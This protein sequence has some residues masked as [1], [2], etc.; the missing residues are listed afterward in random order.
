MQPG[1]QEPPGPSQNCRRSGLLGR[2][3]AWAW[4]SGNHRVRPAAQIT[5]WSSAFLLKGRERE[6][7]RM[8]RKHLQL[9]R[10]A[11]RSAGRS[12]DRRHPRGPLQDTGSSGA[13]SLP[14][15]DSQQED[16]GNQVPAELKPP[17]CGTAATL[18]SVLP[19]VAT[20]ASRQVPWAPME[21]SDAELDLQRSVQAVLRELSAQAPALQSDRGMWRWSL[22]KKVERDPGKSPALVRILLRELE[23]AES[24]DIR[25][26]I[27][28]LLHTLMYVVTKAT[29]ITEEL[30][31]RTYAFCTRLLTLPAPYCTVA[32]DCAI[33]LKTETVVPGTLY[34]RLVIAEQNLTNELY[35][36]QERAFLFVDP[37]LVSPSVCSALLLELEAAQVQQTPEACMRH[38]VS[39]ALQAALGDNCHASALQRTLQASPRQALERYFHAVVAAVEQMASE[40][41]PS[42]EG[43]LERLEEIYCSLLG[44]A[45]AR[46]RCGGDPLQD[47][48]PSI[49]LPSPHI[50]FHLWT[51]E[52]QLWKELV[53]FLR[54]RSQLCLSADLEALDLQGLWPDRELARVSMLSTDSGIERDLPPGADELP[55][56]GSPEMERAGLQR[57]GGIKKRVRLPDVFMPACWDGPPGLH[58]RTGRPSGD[59]ELL[60]GVSRL[61]TA[62]V[63]VLGDDR[64]LG[65]LAQAYHSLRKRETQK[66]C[67]TPR[68]S[69]QLYYIPVLAPEKLASPCKHSEL[70]E[71]ATFL[72]RADPWYESIVNTLCPAIHKLAEMPPS[73][74]TSR[75]VDPFILDVIT[76]YLRM[77]TQPI[78]FQIYTVKIFRDLSQQ[79]AEDIFLTE[80]KVKIQDTKSPKDG[81][82]PRRRGATEGPG[83]E[84]NIC[85]QKALLSH[86]AQEVTVSLRATGLVLKALASSDTEGSG[87]AHA[88]PSAPVMDH[89]CLNVSVT[90]VVKSSNLAG[91][92]FSMVTN[93]FRTATVQIQSQDQRPLTLLLDKDSRRTFKDVVRLEVSPCPEPCSAAHK[94]KAPRPSSHKQEAEGTKAK[95]K[96]L[97]MPIN[98]F[99]GIVQ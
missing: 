28:P 85:Y 6:L 84:L 89:T 39:H 62:R 46:G 83:A 93:T 43:H 37:E 67:L 59:G 23:K 31:R 36:Y 35:P 1:P 54:P 9:Q 65:R 15:E 76:Y 64:M 34:Q 5:P 7:L 58:R 19:P 82:S 72:G 97:L 71:V 60:P 79:P 99:S 96:P 53:L 47:P 45:A 51:D 40:P 48:Q 92:S 14:V 56:P 87:P 63:L 81:F 44:P 24:E 12:G 29:G 66:F 16:L 78:Y 33:R 8:I 52:E 27:I 49:P 73:L 61:H 86:R 13:D 88:P 42:R 10:G 11:D 91:R 94:S 32:L 77:G 20:T 75:T 18:L 21:S 70:R 17:L 69:L 80:L 22:H 3:T 68:L 2:V 57:K 90:E 26:V 98:T 55:V 30:Y 4:A 50:T 41:S 74:D 95:P 38:V 25:H